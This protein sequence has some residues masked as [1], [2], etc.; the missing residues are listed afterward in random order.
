MHTYKNKVA[1]IS[2]SIRGLGF[3]TA[4]HLAK[5]GY[6]VILNSRA[7]S[8]QAQAVISEI[9]KH[10]PKSMLL[11]GDVVN[12]AEVS[13]LFSEIEKGF[14]RL[15]VLINN[16][17]NFIYKPLSETS[18]SE[19]SDVIQNNLQSAFLCSKYALPLMRQNHFGRI[20]SFGSCGCDRMLVRKF[21]T[22]Y[23]IAKTGILL[24]TK[25][26]AMEEAKNGITFNTISPGILESSVVKHP[27]PIGREAKFEDIINAI[28]FLLKEESQYV[29]GANI[30]V[31]GGLVL[32]SD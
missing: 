11:F 32:G 19:F 2:G 24:M 4:L 20:I 1:L 27:T 30:K 10:S 15:D 5:C 25:A 12:E 21:T 23:Y 13:K 16:V 7:E 14:G 17:G 26:F 9:K 18:P 22:P 6:V 31:A 8:V 29:N 3:A 28:D